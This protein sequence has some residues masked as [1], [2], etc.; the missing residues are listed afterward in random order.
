MK[1]KINRNLD[2]I[3]LFALF[4]VVIYHLFV[5][6]QFKFHGILSFLNP[7][8]SFGGEFTTL[9]FIIS[10][11]GIY[12][13]IENQIL[14]DKK[15]D[16]SKF[17]NR[18]FKKLLPLYIFSIVIA[19]LFTR[20]A[21]NFKTVDLFTHL[22]F[23]HNLFPDTHGSINGVLWTMAVF[24]QFYYIAYF[25]YLCVKKHP[26]I[27]YVL[28]VIFSI[29]F[30]VVLYHLIL[31][32]SEFSSSVYYF[33]YGKQ[34]FGVLDS[35]VIGMILARL[36][37]NKKNIPT[38][39]FGLS[40]VATCLL[41]YYARRGIYLDNMFSYVFNSV[42]S[43][44]LAVN[45]YL[46]MNIKINY[47]SSINK[48]LLF[49]SKHE[50]SIYLWHYLIFENL[51]DSCGFIIYSR[52][53]VKMLLL[54][55]ISVSYSIV[56]SIIFSKFFD[57]YDFS[58]ISAFFKKYKKK[59]FIIIFVLL[60]IFSV[61]KISYMLKSIAVDYNKV[62]TNNIERHDQLQNVVKIIKNKI[63]KEKYTYVLV[64]QPG[65]DGF[66]N[67]FRIRYYLSPNENYV[68]YNNTVPIFYNSKEKEMVEFIKKN[69][70]DYIIF[71]EYKFIESKII[72]KN[73]KHLYIYSINKNKSKCDS[74]EELLVPVNGGVFK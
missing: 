56:I 1:S 8:I 60:T 55:L 3:K 28:S 35:F 23:I 45:V 5:I 57:D 40:V 21:A 73:R 74:L 26:K 48:F 27:T 29:A 72:N 42:F 66:M 20:H 39:W 14:K 10:G 41:I 54:I 68:D 69:K 62:I 43:L 50:Y 33:I 36:C 30:K 25:M 4:M 2:L 22:L 24:F 19:C 18:R 58:R 17:I 52:T 13:S 38:L 37:K 51:L 59:I 32:K 7:L 9:F 11:Y 70:F 63:P 67:F 15:F 31:P 49:I 71:H 65:Y 46:F 64:D 61:F 6:L 47:D 12:Y 44:A 53:S 34:L 16:F